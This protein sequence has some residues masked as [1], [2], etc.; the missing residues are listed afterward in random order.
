MKKHALAS[1]NFCQQ[2]EKHTSPGFKRVSSTTDSHQKHLAY[3]I[4]FNNSPLFKSL[5]NSLPIPLSF[6]TKSS[7]VGLLLVRLRSRPQ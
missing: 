7:R 2:M 5:R 3:P 1:P 4:L 6:P